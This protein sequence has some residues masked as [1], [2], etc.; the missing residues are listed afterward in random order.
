MNRCAIVVGL[1]CAAGLGACSTSYSV[2]AENH[3][4][5]PVLIEMFARAPEGG[6]ALMASALRLGPGDKWHLAPVQMDT[7]RSVFLRVDSLV[8]P[9]DPVTLDLRPGWTIV[10]VTQEGDQVMGRLHVRVA[11]R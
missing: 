6:N 9:G 1:V 3:T 11:D 10:E 2:D 4:P 8:R 7:V 5:Q